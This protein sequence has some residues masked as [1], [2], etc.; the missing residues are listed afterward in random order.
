MGVFG[1]LE[2]IPKYLQQQLWPIPLQSGD[3][4]T[5]YKDVKI[6]SIL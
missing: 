2:A 3:W 6:V 4:L 1:L 5:M